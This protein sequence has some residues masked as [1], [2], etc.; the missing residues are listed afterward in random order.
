MLDLLAIRPSNHI[1]EIGWGGSALLAAR[2]RGA[3]VTAVTIAEDRFA[4]YRR[5]PD[6]DRAT[7]RLCSRA[8]ITGSE[9]KDG[10]QEA[11]ERSGQANRR[12]EHDQA[13]A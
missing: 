12:I 7:A 5:N 1:L 2:E 9:P 3:K 11:A 4:R 6:F 8:F 13:K 10:I